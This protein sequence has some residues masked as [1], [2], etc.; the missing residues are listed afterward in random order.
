MWLRPRT[1]LT[2]ADPRRWEFNDDPQW[3]VLA[4]S[5]G[6]L[7]VAYLGLAIFGA[8]RGRPI[9]FLGLAVIFLVLRSAFL[10]SL[11]NPETRYSLE[12]YPRGHLAG[13]GRVAREVRRITERYE[14]PYRTILKLEY[15]P[16]YRR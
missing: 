7:N 3:S 16:K 5:L 13:R 12:C 4:V 15:P 6:V 14:K 2:P 8:I 1:E 9:A 11:E 10:G